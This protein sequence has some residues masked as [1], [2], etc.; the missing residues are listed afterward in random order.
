MRYTIEDAEYSG[1]W[2]VYDT[3][4]GQLVWRCKTREAASE[5]ANDL[6]HIH[7][8]SQA[9]PSVPEDVAQRMRLL[10]AVSDIRGV[11]CLDRADAAE[12]CGAKL[13]VKAEYEE[14]AKL[15]Q[16]SSD[17]YLLLK[18]AGVSVEE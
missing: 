15:R 18:A 3:L 10:A 1:R 12:R 8:S 6:E 4:K 7:T 11:E 13:L 14:A 5:M 17:L 9:A 2:Y 16:R